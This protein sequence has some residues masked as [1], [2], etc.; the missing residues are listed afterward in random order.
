MAFKN[1]LLM[2]KIAAAVAKMK[3]LLVVDHF[4]SGGAQRQIVEL[5]SGLHA[6]GHDV[7]MFVYFPEH[8]FFRGRLEQL[9]VRVHE[10]DKRRVGSLG[11]LRALV[12]VIRERRFDIVVSFLSGAN[13]YSEVAKLLTRRG[14]LVV[15][16][17]TSYL[18]DKSFF[19]AYLRR[20]LHSAADFV[21]ANSESQTTWL[22]RRWWLKGKVG[23]IYNGLEL[24]RYACET[25]IP[26]EREE[27]RL[28]AIGRIGVEKN[29]LNVIR[30]LELF[31]RNHGYVPRFTWVGSRDM[32]AAGEAYGAQVHA[33]LD[34]LPEVRARWEWL[35]LQEDIPQLLAEH[36]ALV[37]A[38][39]Y[40]GL[41]NA[42]CESLA[43]GR[44]V[45]ASRVCDH[46]LLI[47]EGERGFLF[48]PMRPEDINAALSRLVRLGTEEWRALSFNARQFANEYLSSERMVA[49][50]ESLFTGM[51]NTDSH[52]SP[53]VN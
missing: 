36:H 41:P 50:Y 8:A 30:A 23:C 49:A 11:V 29:T 40:E 25:L 47:A 31:R 24:G 32:S 51:L 38:S 19:S 4:G 52:Q 7:E 42:V 44:P 45:L 1:R 39:F 35:G 5:A 6:R 2:P 48:D 26:R 53:A 21:V 18:D 37:H 16:E 34:S 10:S 17:R 20:M 3:I 14:K 33:L 43:A 13:I 28:L 27:I 9:H 12:S 46:P 15:S 22:M